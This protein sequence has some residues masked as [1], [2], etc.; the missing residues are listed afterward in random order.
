MRIMQ[1]PVGAYVS[2]M[3]QNKQHLARSHRNASNTI[4]AKSFIRR[5]REAER[6]GAPI[7]PMKHG[8]GKV[9]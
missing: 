8:K 7:K 9:T 2:R 5:Q 4:F 6:T 1:S 3:R